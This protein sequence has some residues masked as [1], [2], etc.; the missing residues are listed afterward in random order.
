MISISYVDGEWRE[1]NPNILGPMDQSFWFATMVFDGARAFDGVA[2]DLDLHCQRLFDSAAVMGEVSPVALDEMIDIGLRTAARFP[3]SSQ[4]YLRQILYYATEGWLWPEPESTHF[5]FS[6]NE[7]P[8]PSANGFSVCLSRYRQPVP[9]TAPT[10]AKASCLYPITGLAIKDAVDKGFGN[11]VFLDHQGNVA[12]FGT[13]NLLSLR[14]VGS[15]RLFSTA[16]F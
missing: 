12:E 5:I 14:M 3:V 7:A 2:P 8:L 11:A 13:S 15:I 10:L 6:I 4:L 16:H 9:D 1:G